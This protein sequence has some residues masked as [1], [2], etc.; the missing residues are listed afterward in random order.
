MNNSL[1]LKL[2]SADFRKGLITAVFVGVALPVLALL[3]SAIQDPAFSIFALN[4][5]QIFVIAVN[6]AVSGFF[7]YLSKNLLT[8][9]NGDFLGRAK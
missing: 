3:Q 2:N 8:D 4:W 9:S 7:G 1:F 5:H 6:G